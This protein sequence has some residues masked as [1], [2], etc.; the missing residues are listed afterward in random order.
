MENGKHQ[1][2]YIS[3]RVVNIVKLKMKHILK[4]GIF[5]CLLFSVNSQPDN[6]VVVGYSDKAT[7]I[8]QKGADV[9][10][11]VQQSLD[12]LSSNGGGALIFEEGLYIL[13]SNLEVGSNIAMIGAGINATVLKLVDKAKP[14]W[15]PERPLRKAGFINSEDTNNLY[16]ANFTLDGNK[17]NQNTDKFSVYG[18]FGLYTEIV[19]N[20]TIDGMGIINFQGYGFDPHGIK[21]P[22]QWSVGLTIINSYAANNDWDGFTIDQT[23][24]VLLKNNKAYNNG[25]HGFNIVTGSYNI[26]IINN[27]AYSNGF[28]FY[29]GDAGC[30]L[31]IQNNLNY[32]TRNISVINNIFQDNT[33]AGICVRDVSGIKLIDNTISNVNYTDVNPRQCIE[34]SR[35]IDVVEKSNKCSN[36]LYVPIKSCSAITTTSFVMSMLVAILTFAE[37]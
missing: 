23:T 28:Y 10:Q 37:F 7:L 32:N 20:V 36:K 19:D 15:M 6:K 13:S 31:A 9:H 1:Q 30:G 25:R 34:I 27:I 22:K 4:C 16:F 24:S 18:R 2:I 12:M 29:L 21:E 26:E 35:S 3:V 17:E 8:V 5:L 33:D 11:Q 14:W